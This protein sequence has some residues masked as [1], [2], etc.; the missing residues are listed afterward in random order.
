[1]KQLNSIIRDIKTLFLQ[2]EEY[3][4]K[5]VII[6]NVM[7]NDYIEYESN[8]DRNKN[9]S[10]KEYLNVI[11]PYLKDMIIDLQISDTWKIQLTIAINFI[12]SKD[13]DE[14]CVIHSKSENIEVMPYDDAYEVLIKFLSH[15]FWDTTLV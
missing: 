6:S 5:A 3:Y 4:C 13:V 8:S 11:K 1:M 9:V 2:E 10:V 14:Q 15:F 12:S 7:N